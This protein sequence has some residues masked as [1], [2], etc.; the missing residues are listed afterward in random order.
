MCCFGCG[1]VGHFYNDCTNPDKVEYRKEN[2]PFPKGRGT[3]TR[4]KVNLNS[5]GTTDQL[6]GTI[7]NH[8]QKQEKEKRGWQQKYKKAVQQNEELQ[9]T[10]SKTMTTTKHVKTKTPT[11]NKAANPRP[12]HTKMSDANMLSEPNSAG[13]G[14]NMRCV[15]KAK[16]SNNQ[17]TS[18]KAVIKKER[19][20]ERKKEWCTDQ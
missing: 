12:R 8:L 5:S 4:W 3:D 19:V 2:H 6:F 14:K 15:K 7:L 18:P 13:P 10:V 9:A 16:K 11:T 1:Q 17:S 20:S